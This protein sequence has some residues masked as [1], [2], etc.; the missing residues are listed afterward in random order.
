MDK[1]NVVVTDYTGYP[2]FT[3]KLV[4]IVDGGLG[5]VR[6]DEYLWE[7][8]ILDVLELQQVGGMTSVGNTT[9]ECGPNTAL[10]EIDIIPDEFPEDIL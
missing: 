3:N 10:F 1:I 9:L 4:S 7:Q 8:W 6:V 2:F 5:V